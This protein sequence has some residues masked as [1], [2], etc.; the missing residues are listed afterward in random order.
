MGEGWG[1]VE[2]R[3]GM[4]GELV[5]VCWQEVPEWESQWWSG[6][7]TFHSRRMINPRSSSPAPTATSTSHSSISAGSSS[8]RSESMST[9]NWRG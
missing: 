4:R 2:M 7:L 5:M 1:W 9:E 6:V 3:N 8:T